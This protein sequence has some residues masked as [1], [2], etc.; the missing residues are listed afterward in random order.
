[1][2]GQEQRY[3]LRAMA[4]LLGALACLAVS[5][6]QAAAEPPKKA[7]G[8]NKPLELVVFEKLLAKN[9]DLTYDQLIAKLKNRQYLDKLSFDPTQAAHF[10]AVAKKMELTQ[11]ERDLF[12]KNGFVSSDRM[13]RHSFSSAYYQI[14]TFDL[15]VLVTSDSIMHALHRAYDDI[16]MEMELTLFT[17]TIDD[18]LA[19]CHQV[20]A[21]KASNN[22][23]AALAANYRDVDLYLT[24]ARN[25]LVGAG[26]QEKDAQKADDVWAGNLLIPSRLEMDKEALARLKDVQSLKLQHPMRTPP[27]EIY[28]GARF[29]DYSQFKPRGH[30]TKS[31]ELKRYFRCLMWLG[32]VDC[33]WNV[34]PTDGTPGVN[35]DSDRELRDAVLMVELLQASNSMKSLKAMDDI[36]AFM[37]GRSDN[38]TVFALRDLLEQAKVQKLADVAG[39]DALGRLKTVIKNGKQAQQMIRSQVV[40]SDPNDPYYKVPPPSTFQL[41][42]QRF[43]IDSFVLSQVV[44][45]SIIFENKKQKRMMPRGLD[46]MA[47]LGNNQAVPLLADDLRKWNYSAN[48]MSSR[49]FVDL[50]KPEF[51]K[52]NLYNLWL[53]SLRALHEDMNEHKHFPQA[54][55]TK[56][57]QMKQLQTQLGS[58]AELRHDTILYAKQS[59]TAGTKCEYPA[60]YVEPYPEF[61]GRVKYFA[62]EAGRRFQAADYSCKVPERAAQLKDVKQRQVKFCKTMAETLGALQTL[63]RKELKAEPFTEQEKAFIK[64]TIDIRGGGSGPPHYDGWFCELFYHRNECAKWDPTIADVHTDPDSNSCLEVGVG[65]VNFAVIAIDNDKDRGVFV[66]PV[67]SYYE[68][69]QP[70]ANRLTDEKWHEMI[71]VQKKDDLPARP[72]WVKAFQASPSERS[73]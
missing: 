30:Y 43:I 57:W 15:P 2:S 39:A 16:L 66:G 63:A 20:L 44:F 31:T 36:L 6:E 33:G 9:Q 45:D 69:H 42:G 21:D 60:G 29:V 41:F 1:M 24:V 18:I 40:I 10:D 8:K 61:Y 12:A 64:K 53:D 23:D 54:M 22:K 35:S 11:E 47:A 62:E 46:V 48:L 68:F 49:E 13:R 55:R 56:A 67:Y 58:W 32:R 25:L 27:T 65:D 26:A 7:A 28:G 37:I 72:S 4:L 70:T 34:L 5:T 14:Y 52:D 38:L 19:E 71:L 51:W 3:P 17:W 59:Y 50:H 73:R